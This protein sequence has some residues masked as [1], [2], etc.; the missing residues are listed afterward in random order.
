MHLNYTNSII[1]TSNTVIE[2]LTVPEYV[3]SLFLQLYKKKMHGI[4]LFRLPTKKICW[5]KAPLLPFRE[6]F[7]FC[8]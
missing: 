4:I 2:G 5:I 1:I 6:L 8:F 3:I 7:L